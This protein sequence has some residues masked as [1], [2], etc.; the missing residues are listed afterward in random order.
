MS[1]RKNKKSQSVPTQRNAAA[2]RA[3]ERQRSAGGLHKDRR[4]RRRNRNSWRQEEGI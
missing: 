1:K 4:D 3:G 2:V